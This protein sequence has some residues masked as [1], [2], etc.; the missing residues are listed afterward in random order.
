MEQVYAIVSKLG[1]ELGDPLGPA[2]PLGR[3]SPGRDYRVRLTTGEYVVRLPRREASLLSASRRSERLANEMA[4]G[5]GIA[6]TVAGAGED[7]LVIRFIDRRP[8]DPHRLAADPG[9]IAVMLRSFHESGLVLPVRFS[10]PE[11]L[12]RY[13]SIVLERGGTLPDDYGEAQGLTARITE[14]LPLT[15]PVPCHNNLLNANV[16]DLAP[17]SGA[18]GPARV[19]LVDW[20]Y[21]AMGHRLFDLA[22]LAVHNN[23]DQQADDRLLAAYFGD[24]V[25]DERRAALRLMRLMV[26][27]HEAARGLAQS[28]VSEPGMDYSREAPRHFDQLRRAASEPGLEDWLRAASS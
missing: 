7:W 20:E 19:A 4:A 5:L 10:V 23:F 6:P 27:A 9:P 11:L 24:P 16:L 26:H 22:S 8:V 1:A 3:G 17:G 25:G 14:T 28:A 18:V 12:D 2:Q 21:A 15:D 13:A